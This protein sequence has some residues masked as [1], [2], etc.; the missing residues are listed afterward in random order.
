MRLPRDIDIDIRPVPT[1]RKPFHSIP[2]IRGQVKYG[3]IRGQVKYVRPVRVLRFG[4]RYRHRHPTCPCDSVPAIRD[5]MRRG[6]RRVAP[7]NQY[8]PKGLLRGGSLQLFLKLK[9]F[10]AHVLEENDLP[11]LADD[12]AL[13][14]GTGLTGGQAGGFNRRYESALFDAL[15]GASR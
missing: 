7:A 8:L 9:A 15:S 11:C 10:Q 12:V 3:D 6:N 1:I 14:P 2:S 13:P 5:H 4:T